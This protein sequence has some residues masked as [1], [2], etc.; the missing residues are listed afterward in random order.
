MALRHLSLMIIKRISKFWC[1]SYQHGVFKPLLLIV[2]SWSRRCCQIFTN[3]I[4]SL[5]VLHNGDLVSGSEDRSIIIW[6]LNK[7]SRT[8]NISSF[9]DKYDWTPDNI[10]GNLQT[11]TYEQVIPQAQTCYDICNYCENAGHPAPQPIKF[12]SHKP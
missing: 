12:Y 10:I 3:S 4:S 9:V 5:A 11:Q 7:S 2:L 1:V 6:D 8:P